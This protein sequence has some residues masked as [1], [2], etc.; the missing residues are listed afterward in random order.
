METLDIILIGYGVL[1]V[2]LVWDNIQAHRRLDV[3][4]DCL[5]ETIQKH[6]HLVEDIAAF[7]DEMDDAFYKLE[8]KND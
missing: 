5:D 3:H 8:K 1:L 7:A 2:Y 6:N 4:E